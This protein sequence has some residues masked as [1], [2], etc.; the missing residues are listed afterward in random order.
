MNNIGGL[1]NTR[2]LVG[3][4][5]DSLFGKIGP[6]TFTSCRRAVFQP[7]CVCAVSTACVLLLLIM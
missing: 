3:D 7:C 1:K 6:F 2:S 5:L 4:K